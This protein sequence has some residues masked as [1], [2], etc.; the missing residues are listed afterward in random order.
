MKKAN[1]VFSQGKKIKLRTKVFPH[2]TG[3]PEKEWSAVFPDSLED[4]G[5]FKT[6]D[7]STLEQFKFY[8]IAVY[9]GKRMVGA[10]T[11]FFMEYPLET[12]ADGK[13]KELIMRIKRVFP[14][15]MSLRV[16][17][18]GL[19]MGPGRIGV[20]GDPEPV[21]KVIIRRMERIAR[22]KRARIIAFKDL[23]KDM[24]KYAPI[25]KREGF[26]CYE[27]L[28]STELPITFGSF[29]EYVKTLGASSRETLRR[30]L[31]KVEGKID[32]A[33][34]MTHRLSD[35]EL[36]RVYDL[37]L[38]TVARSE[39]QFEVMT[40]DFFRL[41]SENMRGKVHYFLWRINGRIDAFTLCLVSKDRFIDYYLGF[42]YSVS[43]DYNLYYIRIKDLLEWCIRHKIKL[44]DMGYTGYEGKRRLGFKLVPYHLFVKHR[45]RFINPMFK[46]LCEFLKPNDYNE[47]K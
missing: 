20:T 40:K 41:I 4:Y 30:K 21:L 37:Y 14:R 7:E 22:K 11:C 8:Y 28:P 19:P 39:Q 18:G 23:D 15:M 6:L 38:Q 34:K 45:S 35:Q 10:S 17:I 1:H 12:T 26:S 5:F 13:A 43:L 44:Y 32:I 24:M 33:L 36:D 47:K 2:I 3:I 25:I 9:E 27:S 29:E 16:L 31:R 46:L 42:D